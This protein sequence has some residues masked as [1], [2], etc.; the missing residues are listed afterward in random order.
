MLRDPQ[1]LRRAHLLYRGAMGHD[2][3]RAR[4]NSADLMQALSYLMSWRM[5]IAHRA[6][7]AVRSGI[8]GPTE[9]FILEADPRQLSYTLFDMDRTLI[10]QFDGYAHTMTRGGD[11]E[12]T[13][14]WALNPE[15]FAARLAFPASLSVWGR[16]FD[17][18]RFTGQAQRHGEEIVL[19]LENRQDEKL[20]GTLVLKASSRVAIKFE[21][22]T[23][24]IEYVHL[25]WI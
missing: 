5:V 3:A 20:K 19:T 16:S 4:V 6:E 13:P 9:N 21:T 10:E 23:V 25:T 17:A 15:H 18:Y 12:E 1:P 2:D 7:V 22:P 11:A 8:N 24:A 14:R